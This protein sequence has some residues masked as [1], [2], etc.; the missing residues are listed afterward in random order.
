MTDTVYNLEIWKK[1]LQH[2]ANGNPRRNLQNVAEALTKAP[3]F[4]GKLGYDLLKCRPMIL[5][6]MP[7][8]ERDEPRQ[9]EETD[10]AETL[11]WLQVAGLPIQSE[12]PV[13]MAYLVV[14]NE[15]KYHPVRDYLDGLKWDGTPRITGWLPTYM[16]TSETDYTQT[17]GRK[18]LI[19]AV[20]RALKPGCKVDTMLVLEGPQGKRK[21]QS[22]QELAGPWVLENL[23]DMK[24]KEGRQ[25]IQGFW[26]IEESELAS[27]YRSEVEQIKQFISQRVDVFRPPYGK[28]PREFPRQCVL[29]GTTN[30]DAYLRDPTG[31][32]RFWPVK[33]GQIQLRALRRDR[34]Q[35]WAEAVA[36]YRDGATWW[37]TDDE[38]EHAAQEQDARRVRHPWERAIAD[39][40]RL[41]PCDEYTTLQILERALDK[42]VDRMT[43]TDGRIVAQ[44]MRTLGYTSASRAL[45][46]GKRTPKWVLE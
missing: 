38:Q 44:I 3:E 9:V 29:V 31:N 40:I 2:D 23:S 41:N 37:L 16:G 35:L 46:A 32:R 22:L 19:S 13:E 17:V 20:A 27:M 33:C 18:F 39:W 21:S 11:R 7:W 15:T 4:A 28:V 12:R 30:S 25:Q 45:V 1:S 42:T 36:A 5:D 8:D 43:E 26:L 10:I 14:C 6:S 34:D 24:S